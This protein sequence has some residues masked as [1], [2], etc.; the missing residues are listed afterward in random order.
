MMNNRE[1]SWIKQ[2]QKDFKKFPEKVKIEM[3]TALNI[4]LD[5]KKSDIAKPLSVIGS[6]V[7]EIALKYQSD[8]Y[9][10]VYALKI[11]QDIWVIHAFQKKSK[12]GIETPKQEYK[13]I[14]SRIKMLKE[15]L[16]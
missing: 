11:D 9:R 15:L 4:A 1:I 14:Q 8:A 10:V 5:G 7:F 6:G 2:A 13:I 3:T 16:K 12:K